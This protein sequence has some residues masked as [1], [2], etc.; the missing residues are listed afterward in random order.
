[1]WTKSRHK[2]AYVKDYELYQTPTYTEVSETVIS[3]KMGIGTVD[4]S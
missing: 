2:S 1:M 3:V 4:L